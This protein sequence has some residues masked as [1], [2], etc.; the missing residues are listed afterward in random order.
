MNKAKKVFSWILAT[1]ILITLLSGCGKKQNVQP[2]LTV[3]QRQSLTVLNY[4]TAMSQEIAVSKDNR[5]FLETAYNELLGNVL[6]DAVDV[7][8]K[9]QINALSDGMHEFR[10]I[11]EKREFLDYLYEQ[12]QA[13]KLDIDLAGIA[14]ELATGALGVLSASKPE[15]VGLI[16]ETL[17]SVGNMAFSEQQSNSAELQYLKDGWELDAKAEDELHKLRM[18]TFNYMVDIVN[19]NNIPGEYTLTENTVKD[20]VDW[21]NNENLTGRIQ[22]LE[23]SQDTYKMFGDYWLTLASSYYKNGDYQKCVDAVREYEE[24]SADLKIFRKDYGY[25]EVLPMY[26]VSVRKVFKESEY[27][28]TAPKY[29]ELILANCDDD[30]WVN[31]YFVAEIY[32]E[33][34]QLTQEQ[35]HLQKAYEVMLNLVNILMGQQQEMNKRYLQEI[36]RADTV[37]DANNDRKK[38]VEQYNKM[39]EELRKT[40]LPPI[41]KSL[42]MSAEMLFALADKLQVSNEEKEKI[43]RILHNNGEDLFYNLIY[44]NT[45]RM[46]PDSTDPTIGKLTVEYTK[47]NGLK[48]PVILLTKDSC[49]KVSVG[50]ENNVTWFDDWKLTSVDRQGENVENFLAEFKSEKA[51]AYKGY[52]NDMDLIIHIYTDPNDTEPDYTIKYKVI[53]KTTLW[54]FDDISFQRLP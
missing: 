54:V 10:M 37:N 50:N 38:D 1:T 49:I 22:F 25:G 31:R 34:H 3:T 19:E 5:L 39:Q 28:K 2:E 9:E 29:L 40:E 30:D 45:I 53:V 8:T 51:K 33:L 24:L 4:L 21:K 35:V 23:S 41:S 20:Y 27:I 52:K 46:N 11:E 14:G 36:E 18:N 42:Y 43:E 44:D 26:L 16:L 7:Q 32:V 13:N 17:I 6:P 15:A 48:L 12:E 47:G